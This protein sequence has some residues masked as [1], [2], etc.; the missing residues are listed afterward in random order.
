[1]VREGIGGFANAFGYLIVA[2][3]A[4]VECH[5]TLTQWVVVNLA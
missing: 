3:K 4:S 1:M 2:R 5:A